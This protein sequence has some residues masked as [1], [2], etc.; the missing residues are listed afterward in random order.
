M[1]TKL[2]PKYARCNNR[3]NKVSKLSIQ[4]YRINILD[5]NNEIKFLHPHNNNMYYDV[6]NIFSRE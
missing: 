1:Q 3:H 2:I 5:P 6:R 4:N